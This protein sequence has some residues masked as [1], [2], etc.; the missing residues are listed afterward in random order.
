MGENIKVNGLNHL[1][2][3]T[4]NM[5]EQIKYF[6][7]VLGMRLRALY[8]MHGLEGCWHGFLELNESSQIAFVFS[9]DN[10][11]AK[12]E[13]GSTHPGTTSGGVA[14]GAM[15]HLALNVDTL[16]D[17]LNMRDRIRSHGINVFGPLD[18]GFCHSIY[19]QGPEDL[20]LEVATF[21]NA[22]Y[23]IGAKDWV[24]PEVQELAG[25]SDEE[26]AEFVN[27]PE[28]VGKGGTVPQPKI[29]TAGYVPAQD[30]DGWKGIIE[31][32]DEVIIAQMSEPLPPSLMTRADRE[33]KH[34]AE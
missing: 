18:H 29:D 13:Y 3:S 15:Q 2:L 30:F 1:A 33:A 6:T 31:A 9:P 27:P 5:K 34:A 11:K 28:F 23:P 32:P 24:D 12:V 26:L 19:F 4:T 25:I 7:N 16:E 20:C 22:D 14:R 10:E 8:W 17:L 21:G